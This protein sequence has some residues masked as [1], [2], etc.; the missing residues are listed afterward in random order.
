M[1]I[2]CAGPLKIRRCVRFLAVRI[3]NAQRYCCP[4]RAQLENDRRQFMQDSTI[5]FLV[6]VI[7]ILGVGTVLWSSAGILRSLAARVVD[8]VEIEPPG[9]LT[10]ADVAILIAAH[11]EELVIEKTLHSAL[12]Q[13]P[14]EQ[15][16]VA[17]DG[18]SDRTSELARALGANVYDIN[19]NRGKAGAIVA[20]ID[21]FDLAERFEV[22]LLLDAD[23]VLSA[24]YLETGLL[25]FDDPSVVAVAGR[26]STIFWPLPKT[27]VGKTLVAYRQRVYIAVQYLLKYGQASRFVNAVTIVPGFASMYR[28]RVLGDIDI[29]AEG[30]TIED[31]NMTFDIHSKDLGRI[32]FNPHAAIAHTQDPD[33]IADYVKQIGRWSLGFW[34]T[35]IRHPPRLRAF[36]AVL[37]LYIVEL[38]SSSVL[39]ILVVPA[40]VVSA[41]GGILALTGEDPTGIGAALSTALPPGILILGVVVPDF[42]LTIVTAIVSRKPI[43][44]IVG[45]AFPIVRLVDALVC[46]RSL[47]RAFDRSSSGRWTSPERRSQTTAS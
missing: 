46:L 42:I 24:D 23:T 37:W 30:F 9:R 4:D 33:T 29:A 16:F 47:P 28:T 7:G 36:Y 44:L 18:S 20:S 15:I 14:A 43:F 41:I 19:P 1:R 13:V 40:V 8:P 5:A 39:V 6:L 17:S 27:W 3:A 45:L 26:A 11:N 10:S 22:L 21:Y 2:G 38:V 12:T 31:Y 32:A 35:V 34:Q 25:P